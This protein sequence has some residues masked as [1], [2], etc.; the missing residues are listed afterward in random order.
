MIFGLD[1]EEDIEDWMKLSSMKETYSPPNITTVTETK[2]MNF[3][4]R[5]VKI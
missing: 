5:F 2:R 1:R 3:V 4:G